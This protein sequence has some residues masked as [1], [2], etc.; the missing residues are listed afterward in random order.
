[1][2]EEV[3]TPT[4]FDGHYILISNQDD[5]GTGEARVVIEYVDGSLLWSAILFSLPSFAIVGWVIA[6]LSSSE[7]EVGEQTPYV[8][9]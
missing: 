1:M 4:V 3:K 2:F 7:D 6:D 5:F 8:K 9:A